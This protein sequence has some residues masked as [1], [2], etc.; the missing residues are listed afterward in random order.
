MSKSNTKF[1]PHFRQDE[2]GSLAIVFAL[3][4]TMV[5]VIVGG[6]VDFARW[7]NARSA[8]VQ[9]LDAAVIAG[10]RELLIGKTEAQA[11]ATAQKFYD[12]NKAKFLDVDSVS[13]SVGTS[14]N[15]V[16]GV[17]DSNVK[18]TLLGIAGIMKLD[19]KETSSAKIQVGANAGQDVEIA[20]MLDTTGSMAGSKMVALKQAAIDLMNIT[21][22][23][24]QSQYT[25]RIAVVPFSPHVNPGRNAFV[26]ATNYSPNGNSDN[27]T[28]VKERQGTNRYTDEAPNGTNGY[29]DYYT[30]NNACRP[31]ATVLPLTSNKQAIQQRINEMQPQAATA[32]H[33]GTGWTWYAL[34]PNFSSVWPTASAPKSYSLLT[35]VNQHGQPKLRKIAILMT[36]GEYNTKYSGDSSATQARA[37]CTSMKAKG[38]T[39]YTV[40]F[41]ISSG[42]EADTTM[43]QCATAADHYYSADDGEAL[44][45]AFRDIAL[46]IATLR[47]TH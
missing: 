31:Q 32:G 44:R 46:K 12:E 27:R 41:A 15:E 24:D 17:T 21:V 4:F 8:T 42:G 18:T 1:I 2:R 5:V 38:I 10:G 25:S 6:A 22:W 29:F 34:S 7:T 16:I 11:L 43:S 36:D 37:I 47:L 35:Q 45:S 33:L 23:S 3:M 39:V 14:G 9:A 20:L 30:G 19:V 28:C 26:T 13:F 40:G